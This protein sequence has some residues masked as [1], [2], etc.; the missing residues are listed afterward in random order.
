MTYKYT[1]VANYFT[2]TRGSSPR[3]ET[4]SQQAHN[5]TVTKTLIAFLIGCAGIAV[6][7]AIQ[8]FVIQ[9]WHVVLF[10]SREGGAP[11][12]AIILALLP[13]V[14]FG[15]AAEYIGVRPGWRMWASTVILW[16]SSIFVFAPLALK[17]LMSG[18][19]HVSLDGH[20]MVLGRW[21][22]CTWMALV[23]GAVAYAL[24]PSNYCEPCG[25]Y[26]Q[27]KGTRSYSFTSWGECVAFYSPLW[28]PSTDARQLKA[29]LSEKRPLTF[30]GPQAAQATIS[31]HCC[32][33]C[34]NLRLFGNVLQK[35]G[36][37]LNVVDSLT[38]QR[39]LGHRTTGNVAS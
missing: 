8:A 22:E 17:A 32:P 31:L 30:A 39:V 38:R 4:F 2:A 18:S 1:L 37:E 29:I 9:Y 13:A 16:L 24:R 23:F 25:R 12:G 26:F 10:G 34:Q 5:E 20:H 15:F 33:R 6:S 35:Q 19:G 36:S 27:K 7:A 11:Y 3:L 21:W 14:C 28:N